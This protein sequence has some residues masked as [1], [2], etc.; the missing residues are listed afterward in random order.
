M[1]TGLNTT[2]PAVD[3]GT[4]TIAETLTNCAMTKF[5]LR[6]RLSKFITTMSTFVGSPEDVDHVMVLVAFST[7]DFKKNQ[8]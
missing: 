6:V 4:L 5:P 8:K 3:F 7:L 2:S 1:I